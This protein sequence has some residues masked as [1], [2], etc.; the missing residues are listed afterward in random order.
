MIEASGVFPSGVN[1][2]EPFKSAWVAE[3]RKDDRYKK[4]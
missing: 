2:G 3:P 1:K 4:I